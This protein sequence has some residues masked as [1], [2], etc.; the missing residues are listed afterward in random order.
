MHIPR[1]P[2]RFSYAGKFTG[3][4]HVAEADAADPVFT[5]VGTWPPTQGAPV[6]LAGGKFGLPLRFDL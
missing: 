1:L 2:A 4:G 5:H 3:Q 6:V